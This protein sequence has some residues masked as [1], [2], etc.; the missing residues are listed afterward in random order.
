[1][2]S[3]FTTIAQIIQNRR[4]I[5]P[6]MMNGHKIPNG[7][8]A[9]LLELADWAPTHGYT[10]PWRFVVYDTPSDFCSAHAKMY[11]DNTSEAEFNEGVYNNL[12]TQA[13]RILM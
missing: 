8:I 4:T 9:A 13:I 10:E 2:T 12:R 7:H 3:E 6:F 11:K 5:K 1:M